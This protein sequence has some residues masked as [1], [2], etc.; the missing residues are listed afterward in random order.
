M[1]KTITINKELFVDKLAKK[2]SEI[3]NDMLDNDIP[4]VD[5]VKFT[6]VMSLLSAEITRELF[7]KPDDEETEKGDDE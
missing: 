7:S 5:V 2:S 3:A 4:A 6:M 1:E